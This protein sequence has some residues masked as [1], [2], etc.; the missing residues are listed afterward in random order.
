M[1]LFETTS[2]AHGEEILPKYPKLG[3]TQ[4]FLRIL[5]GVAEFLSQSLRK[6]QWP[7]GHTRRTWG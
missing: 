7:H 1:A 6:V 3:G 4:T 5:L 2:S